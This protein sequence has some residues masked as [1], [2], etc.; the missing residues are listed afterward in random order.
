MLAEVIWDELR[1]GA[2]EEAEGQGDDEH[3]AGV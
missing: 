3:L 1:E 2:V